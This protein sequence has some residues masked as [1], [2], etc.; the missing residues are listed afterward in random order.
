VHS[1]PT[2]RSIAL[3]DASTILIDSAAHGLCVFRIGG[4][5]HILSNVQDR[6]LLSG[7]TTI[8]G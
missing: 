8:G 4:S 1:D 2:V 7:L 5:V 6:A 3:A